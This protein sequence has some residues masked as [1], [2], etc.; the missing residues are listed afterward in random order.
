MVG[1]PQILGQVKSAVQLAEESN[2][3][4][5]LLRPLTRQTMLVA[6]KVRT[7]T[8]IGRSTVGVG[9]A[10]IDLAK[11]IF[12]DLS[13]RRALL[14]GAGEMGLEVA[15][16]LQRAGLK[17]LVIA[18]RT[19]ERAVDFANEVGGTPVSID[20]ISEYLP[21]VDVVLT[22]TASP[23]PIVTVKM[24]KAALRKRRY[25]PLFL[26]DLSVPRN[27]DPSIDQ[28]DAAYLFNVDD[29]SG[30]VEQGR[31]AREEASMLAQKMVEDEAS[32]FL[33]TLLGR[34]VN[35]SIRQLSQH[36]ETLRE[37]EL[38]RSKK[39][40]DGLNDEQRK[41]LEIMTQAMMRKVLHG[42][43]LNMKEAARTGDLLRVEDILRLWTDDK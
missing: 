1:E 19:F 29:L 38:S 32:S 42:P 2:A 22:A 31:Q 3:L 33:Q 12:G 6:K 35:P 16:A 41:D 27:I 21:R 34:Q 17:E 24:A 18:N 4:G 14:V 37:N 9:S 26:M 36:F 15:R 43:V 8:E 10:G 30:I 5:A 40:V 11:Q 13:A 25:Q 28:L 7:E 23:T 20:R 39:F